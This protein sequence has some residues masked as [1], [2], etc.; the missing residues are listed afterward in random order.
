M[1]SSHFLTFFGGLLNSEARVH[2][3]V[4]PPSGTK[5]KD[6]AGNNNGSDFYVFTEKV[7]G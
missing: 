1:T 2:K 3:N 5:E 7:A 6:R 4:F